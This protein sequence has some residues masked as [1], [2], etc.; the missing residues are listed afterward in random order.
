M[1][2]GAYCHCARYAERRYD[3][4]RCDERR[5][6]ERR[7]DERRGT[8]PTSPTGRLKM[9]RTSQTGNGRA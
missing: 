7:R 3:E 2:Q 5:Y 9:V 6:D 4:R 8:R 1:T